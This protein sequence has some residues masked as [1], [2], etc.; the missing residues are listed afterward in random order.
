LRKKIIEHEK[1]QECPA[2]CCKGLAVEIKRPRL[3]WQWDQLRWYL[4]FD[5]VSVYVLNHRW[6]LLFD[7]N[8]RYLDE[9]DLCTI[10]DKRS[11][12]CREH[13]AEA[14]EKDTAF[15]DFIMHRPEDIDAYLEKSKRRRK[16]KSLFRR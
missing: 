5:K 9:H 2:V 4:H 11:D 15:Y 1:C 16:K 10:Y 3:K 6:H 13:T 7:T 12:I 8:C 14:C